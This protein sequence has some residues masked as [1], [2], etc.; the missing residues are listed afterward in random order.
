M[1]TERDFRIVLVRPGTACGLDNGS[2]D[3]A[4]HYNGSV[5]TIRL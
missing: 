3:I 4:V 2:S 5:V 1:L